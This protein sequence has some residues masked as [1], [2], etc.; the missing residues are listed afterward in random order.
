MGGQ[1]SEGSDE[2]AQLTR[3]VR[4]LREEIKQLKD[5]R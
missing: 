4:E 5:P 2:V 3:E 1:R